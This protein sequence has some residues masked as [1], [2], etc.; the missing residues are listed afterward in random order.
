VDPK[1]LAMPDRRFTIWLY[2]V[3][4]AAYLL[5]RATKTIVEETLAGRDPVVLIPKVLQLR[6]TENPGG[7]FS[8][9]GSAPWLFLGATVI[10]CVVIVI[11]SRSIHQ[12]TLA[13]GL[14]LVLGG[15]IGNLTDRIVRGP[16]LSG[17]VVDFVDF[18]V[19][20][21]FNAAD[22]AIVVGAGLILLSGAR[23][24]GQRERAPD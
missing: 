15:A 22:S 9:F 12:L 8:L 3:A 20:P 13:A 21:V 10:V 16:G 6:F 23:S 11:A 14:G 2:A 4:G 7:A 18:M 24:R 17:K 1:P 5:D 19:W